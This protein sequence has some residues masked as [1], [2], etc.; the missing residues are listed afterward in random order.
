VLGLQSRKHERL[1]GGFLATDILVASQGLKSVKL[2]HLVFANEERADVFEKKEPGSKM[3]VGYVGTPSSSTFS[4]SNGASELFPSSA[5]AYQFTLASGLRAVH[6]L[7][8]SRRRGPGS[9]KDHR[10]AK[11]RLKWKLQLFTVQ[12]ATEEF[13]GY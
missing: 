3:F 10:E 9:G 13:I 5:V 4:R 8:E 2:V 12:G 6:G 11:R 7:K 1:K